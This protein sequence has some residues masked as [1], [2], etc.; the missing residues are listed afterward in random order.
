MFVRGDMVRLSKS[1]VQGFEEK[2]VY[3]FD[4]KVMIFANG[5]RLNVDE[6]E[7]KVQLVPEPFILRTSAGKVRIEG[8]F[9]FY[10]EDSPPWVA[11]DGVTSETL[12]GRQVLTQDERGLRSVIRIAGT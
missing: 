7:W 8:D 4:G 5:K 6:G 2:K 9:E 12:A 10:R 1:G 3:S 11:E